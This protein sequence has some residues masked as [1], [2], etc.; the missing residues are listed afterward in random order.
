[1]KK[2]IMKK[3]IIV[4]KNDKQRMGISLFIMVVGIAVVIMINST[5][6]LKITIVFLPFVLSLFIL[7]L[8]YETWRIIFESDK[9]YKKVFFL[10]LKRYSYFEIKDAVI[11]HSYTEYH[12]ITISFSDGN[13]LQF[14]LED[15]NAKSAINRICSFRSVRIAK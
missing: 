8:Y 12:C 2:N 13:H 11:W 14:R 9:I 1:M 5:K 15:K 3:N 10:R 4:K 7:W 6:S